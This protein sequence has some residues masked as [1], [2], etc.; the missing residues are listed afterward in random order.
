VDECRHGCP[1]GHSLFFSEF[2]NGL[3]ER[4]PEIYEGGGY[5]TPAEENFGKKWRHYSSIYDLANGDI[6]KFTEVVE[7]PLEKCLLYLSY[8]ADTNFLHTLL[9]KEAIKKIKG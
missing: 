2:I 1:H 6:L 5:S 3:A 8:K 7:M 9:H 4:Y